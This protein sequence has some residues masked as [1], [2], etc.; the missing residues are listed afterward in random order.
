MNVLDCL[1][2]FG[3]Y[4][5]LLFL[6]TRRSACCALCRFEETDI[7]SPDSNDSGIQSDARSDDGVSHV[8]GPVTAEP[9]AV[10]DKK[11]DHSAYTPDTPDSVYEV[12]ISEVEWARPL[13]QWE[14]DICSTVI[15]D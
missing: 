10:V 14:G 3:Y 5:V 12:G 1:V 6:W 4:T 8:H 15:P 2:L 11:A 13:G 7:N 9:Y